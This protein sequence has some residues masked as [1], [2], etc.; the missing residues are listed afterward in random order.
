MRIIIHRR[1]AARTLQY[2][3]WENAVVVGCRVKLIADKTAFKHAFE[4]V[5]YVWNDAM[6]ELLGQTVTVVDRPEPGIFG[7]PKSDANS[8][9]PVWWYPFAVIAEII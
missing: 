9:Q 4:H 5:G 3:E 1:E 2:K 7:L 6:V 8:G